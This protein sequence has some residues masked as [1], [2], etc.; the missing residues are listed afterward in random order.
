MERIIG[1]IGKQSLI[2][3]K[4]PSVL[5]I[6]SNL[7]GFSKGKGIESHDLRIREVAVTNGVLLHVALASGRNLNPGS[8]VVGFY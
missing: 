3:I 4:D 1:E 5:P 8:C 2:N 6:A 7:Y